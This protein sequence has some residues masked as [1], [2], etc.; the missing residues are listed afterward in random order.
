[1]ILNELKYKYKNLDGI[2]VEKNATE[3]IN[4]IKKTILKHITPKYIYLFGSF[5][6]G[7]PKDKSDIDIYVVLPD[8]INDDTELY[9]KIM[10]DLR[11]EGIYFVDLLF[12]SE[13]VFNR[14]KI[15]NILEETIYLKGLLLY[16][17]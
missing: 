9:V 17:N 8:D 16:E 4:L 13:S 12:A 6:Y 14:R 3:V 10:M 2:P 15:E 7:N 11:D 5:A 1:M